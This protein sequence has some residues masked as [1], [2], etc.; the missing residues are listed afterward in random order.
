[1][2]PRDAEAFEWDDASTRE[3]AAHGIAQWE[4]EQVFWNGAVWP[5]NKRGRSGDRKMIG[6]TDAG[7]ALTIIVVVKSHVRTLRFIT[8]WGCTD[9]ERTRYLSKFPSSEDSDR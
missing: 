3:L 6:Y 2:H 4:A 9:S 1:M 7:R 5:K 8:G